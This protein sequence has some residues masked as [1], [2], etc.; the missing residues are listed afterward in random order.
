LRKKIRNRVTLRSRRL[1]RMRGHDPA[2]EDAM[3]S[4]RIVTAGAALG[5]VLVMALSSAVGG[6]AAQTTT[7]EPGKPLK[8][9]QILAQPAKTK[10]KPRAKIA[11]KPATKTAKKSTGKKTHIADRGEHP[12]PGLAPAT[13]DAVPAS[14]WPTVD[15][16]ALAAASAAPVPQAAP[17]PAEPSLSKIVVGGRTVQVAAPDEVNAIDLA[18]DE[19][20]AAMA[21]QSDRADLQPA[22][23]SVVA[24][25]QQDDS[26]TDGPSW[27]AELLATFGGALA[28]GSVAW[29]LIGSAPQRRYG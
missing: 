3:L 7:S 18:A 10:T 26:A 27:I 14:V 8:L 11:N 6:A 15:A 22:S 5:A 16:A 12:A 9:L 17:A 23:D 25:A 13:I 2:M 20:T 24:F 1:C 28:A 21:T 4:I 19:P 29:F